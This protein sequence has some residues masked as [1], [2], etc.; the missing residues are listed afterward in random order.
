[1]YT[2]YG[3]EQ[4]LLVRVANGAE[5]PEEPTEPAAVFDDGLPMF[6]IAFCCAAMNACFC[7]MSLRHVFELSPLTSRFVI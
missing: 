3:S 2:L 6:C 5:R 1:M 7:A 4:A